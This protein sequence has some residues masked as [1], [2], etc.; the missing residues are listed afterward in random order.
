[1]AEQKTPQTTAS[2]RSFATTVTLLTHDSESTSLGVIVSENRS[3][4]GS[5]C[6]TLAR[7]VAPAI[8]ARRAA[9]QASGPPRPERLVRPLRA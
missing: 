5:S 6:S 8:E 2:A 9:G 1:M 4:R 3:C 7:D